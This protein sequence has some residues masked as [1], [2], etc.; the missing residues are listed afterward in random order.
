MYTCKICGK[1]FEK[2]HSLAAHV[3]N[4]THQHY[5]ASRVEVIK[6]CLHCG[7]SFTILKKPGAQGKLNRKREK[8]YCSTACSNVARTKTRPTY[9]C[10]CCGKQINHEGCCSRKCRSKYN[11]ETKINL[12]LESNSFSGIVE[13][14]DTVRKYLVLYHGHKCQICG[15]NTLNNK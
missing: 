1:D 14:P 3:S 7:K 4:H 12:I 5:K 15:I 2:R 9:S 13:K 6:Q 11:Y 8:Q 10:L